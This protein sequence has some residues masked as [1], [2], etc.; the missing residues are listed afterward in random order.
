MTLKVLHGRSLALALLVS[1]GAYAQDTQDTVIVIGGRI[2]AAVE[3]ISSAT[4][5]VD[6][7]D[8]ELRGH[9]SLADTL[10]SLPGMAVSR[11]GGPG[12][13]TDLRVRGSEANHVLVLMDGLEASVPLT[14]G[15]DFARAPGFGVERVEVLRGE[16][17]ALWGPDAIGGVINIRTAG[18]TGQDAGRIQLEAGSFGT[19]FLG[20][21]ASG[22]DGRWSGGV[23][24][25]AMDSE[26]FDISGQGGEK[27]G[28]SRY[29]ASTTGRYEVSEHESIQWAARFA[30]FESEFDSDSDFNGLLNNTSQT[31]AGQQTAVGAVLTSSRAGLRHDLAASVSSDRLETYDAGIFIASTAASR[32]RV[33]YQPTLEWQSGAMAHRLTGL[34]EREEEAFDSYAG[35]RAFSNQTRTIRNTAL[36]AD[37]RL[38]RGPWRLSVSARQDWNER[39]EDALTW[40]A[41][42]AWLFATIGGRV[43]ASWGEGVKNPGI[44]ELFGYYP[45]IFAGNPDLRPERSEG[46]EIGWDQAF[47][48]I[49]RVSATWFRSEL[50]D[51][52]YTDFMVLPA[53]ARNRMSRSERSGFEFGGDVDLGA[54]LS[55]YGSATFLD[56]RENGALELRRPE[57]TGSV[58]LAWVSTSGRWRAGLAAD[59]T[60]AQLDT[61]FGTYNTVELPAYTLVSSRLA[62]RVRDNVELYARAT[63]LT[64]EE[65]IDVYG[66]ASEGRGLFVGV[67][68][69]R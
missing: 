64:D 8:I 61:D 40:R 1:S 37:Y 58:S 6:E 16:Q 52:I 28:F 42:G 62:W 5:L 67:R 43:R 57:T 60:S 47:G 31:S 19:S 2:P 24:F 12:G 34:L 65:A 21:Q 45:G 46:W 30:D 38:E 36:A 53:T 15:Y 27:D 14:G 3:D 59:H 9:T 39:F 63:N 68:L 54:G 22:R 13:L 35:V 11:S 32:F 25:S 26:G 23:A 33:W 55:L 49:A 51:E 56:T 10:R 20:A 41:G 50:R 69:G 66:Y 7:T 48:D 17:S 18:S 29:F 44:Y 4:S